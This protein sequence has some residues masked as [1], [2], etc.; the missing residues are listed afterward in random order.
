M[1]VAA[2]SGNFFRITCRW[3]EGIVESADEEGWDT[4]VSEV[5]FAARFLPVITGIDEAV[6][7]SGEAVVEFGEGFHLFELT[8]IE[9]SGELLVLLND[10]S[11]E[12]IH[13]AAHVNFV[14]PLAELERAGGEVAGG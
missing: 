14:L 7:R 6:E 11:F 1:K 8:E 9:F 12:A 2:H 3:Q 4:D 5:G 10:L 13:E